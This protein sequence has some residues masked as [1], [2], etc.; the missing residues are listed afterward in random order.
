MA[1]NS[2]SLCWMYHVPNSS[3][4]ISQKKRGYRLPPF[5][6]QGKVYFKHSLLVPPWQTQQFPSF[7]KMVLGP[8]PWRVNLLHL[9]LILVLIRFP[10]APVSIQLPAHV[11]PEK[12]QVSEFL[13]PTGRPG[14]SSGLITSPGQTL[15]TTGIGAQWISEWK[16]CPLSLCLSSSLSLPVTLLFKNKQANK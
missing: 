4:W 14:R 2:K 6:A 9:H 7:K 12:Q 16:H 8:V 10:A 5:R 13:P 3:I 1:T 15:N 11:H